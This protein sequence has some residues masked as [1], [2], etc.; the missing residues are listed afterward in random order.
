LR[1]LLRKPVSDMFITSMRYA[2]NREELGRYLEEA[3]IRTSVL[4][5][6]P[7]HQQ[8]G[9]RARVRTGAGGMFNT[10]LVADEILCLPIYREMTENDAA[11][12]IQTIRALL[13]VLLCP[14]RHRPRGGPLA[15]CSATS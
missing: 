8:P 2:T 1:H 14:R 12:V 6:V 15:L 13:R 5:P 11:T 7:V 4:Y 9:Y 10:E 3:G